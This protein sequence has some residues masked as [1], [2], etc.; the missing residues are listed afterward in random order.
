M[1]SPRHLPGH[2]GKVKMSGFCRD[3]CYTEVFL[4]QTG[5]RVFAEADTGERMLCYS[6]HVRGHMTFKSNIDMTQ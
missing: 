6:K 5:E 3:S 4:G 1:G 2:K